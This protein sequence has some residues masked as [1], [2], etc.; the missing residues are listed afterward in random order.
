MPELDIDYNEQMILEGEE[1]YGYAPVYL[2]GEEIGEVTY[3]DELVNGK[4]TGKRLYLFYSHEDPDRGYEA[5]TC[6]EA[7]SEYLRS[8]SL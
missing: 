5:P 6:E 7:V 2:N 3:T 8:T 1:Y 4:I